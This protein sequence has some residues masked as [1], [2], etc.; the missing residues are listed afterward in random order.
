MS[1][2][3]T[4]GEALFARLWEGLSAINGVRC[5]G[6]PPGLPRTPTVSFTI[7]GVPSAEVART[8]AREAVFVSNGNFYAATVVE[9]LG[10]GRD[11][12]VR[13]GCACYTTEEEIERLI[14]AVRRTAL[15]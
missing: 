4:R 15:R 10:H 5:Y 3:H 6:P 13:A 8:L 14:E 2:L 7:A 9:R 1:A 12:L 11:G